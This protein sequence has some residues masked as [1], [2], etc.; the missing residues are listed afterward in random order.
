MFGAFN[1]AP[2]V[3]Q[4]V[5][6]RAERTLLEAVVTAEEPL[7]RSDGKDGQQ[8]PCHGAGVVAI[9]MVGGAVA[10]LVQQGLQQKGVVGCREVAQ[11]ERRP[12]QVVEYK[13]TV[14]E[15]FGGREFY[16]QVV[17]L[18]SFLIV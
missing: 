9:E 10:Q 18:H 2:H 8:E 15:T 12:R 7:P 17:G 1:A 11:H 5:D 4:G 14:A 16:V 6:E 3:A 13:P